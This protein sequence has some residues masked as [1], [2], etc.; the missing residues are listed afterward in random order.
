ML[1]HIY[2]NLVEYVV[3]HNNWKIYNTDTNMQQYDMSNFFSKIGNF[4]HY[5][6]R[7][8]NFK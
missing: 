7:H 5:Q 3:Y 1:W 6:K 8:K 2:Y 4:A